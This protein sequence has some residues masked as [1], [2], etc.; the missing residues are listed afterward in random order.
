M[1]SSASHRTARHRATPQVGYLLFLPLVGL[2]PPFQCDRAV[3]FWCEFKEWGGGSHGSTTLK[4]ESCA[5]GTRR[6]D[7]VLAALAVTSLAS[8]G[9]FAGLLKPAPTAAA[10]ELRE[11]LVDAVRAR[12]APDASRADELIEELAEAK[13]PFR[14]ELL[15]TSSS[16]EA[17]VDSSD[18]DSPLW[19]A[20]YSS[21][22]TPRWEKNAK[23]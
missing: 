21:G 8:G 13:V 4:D 14:T 17:I 1:R 22:P 12:S 16:V 7:M 10:R 19:R 3:R 23:V 6:R 9:F 5:P 20:C 2:T 15:G 18:R 11:L